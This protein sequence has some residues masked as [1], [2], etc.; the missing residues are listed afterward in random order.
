[1]KTKMFKKLFY[2]IYQSSCSIKLPIDHHYRPL[3]QKS[4]L[5]SEFYFFSKVLEKSGQNTFL[6]CRTIMTVDK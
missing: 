5:A 2:K 3:E 6:S 1:M 4:I